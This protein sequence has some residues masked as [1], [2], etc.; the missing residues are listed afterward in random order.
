[1]KKYFLGIALTLIVVAYACSPRSRGERVSSCK[2]ADEVAYGQLYECKF[3]L[4]RCY[5][6]NGVNRGGISC[7]FGRP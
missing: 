6:F 1:M 2:L 4:D 5:I 3:G 7:D